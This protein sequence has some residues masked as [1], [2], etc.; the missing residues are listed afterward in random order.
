[1]AVQWVD[2]KEIKTKVSMEMLLAH[3][4]LL[5]GMKQ[6][7]RGFRG[8]CPI[9]KGKHPNQ[10]HVDPEKNRWNCF[11]G[12][13]MQKLE[14]HVIGFV[15][16]MEKV[17]L[18]EAALMIAQWYG[19]GTKHPSRRPEQSREEEAP[20]IAARPVEVPAP[21]VVPA[22]AEA[23]ASDRQANQEQDPENKELTFQLKNLATEHPFFGERGIL[24]ETIKE[25][26]LGFC[27]K[28]MMK[29]RIVFP[30]HRKDGILIGYTGRTVK[31]IT[32]ENPK[33]LLPPGLVKP[34]VLFNFHRVVGKFRTVIMVEGGTSLV[35]VHQAGFPNVVGLLGKELLED[36]RLSYDQLRLITEHFDQAVVLLDGDKDGRERAEQCAGK[37][38]TGIFTRLVTLPTDKDPADLSPQD[39]QL[40]LAFL[41]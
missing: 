27:S 24:P 30:I 3:Y 15:A 2:F 36:E 32:D 19:L 4:G 35:A 21:R 7:S 25:F 31:E 18:R 28:G 5:G 33:W 40:F 14:G 1:M 38:I 37:L 41:Q 17:N 12:C 20:I 9:H 6:T 23:S 34:K 8:P 16:A 26:G 39:L 10:F 22:Q 13:D 11:G 29:D